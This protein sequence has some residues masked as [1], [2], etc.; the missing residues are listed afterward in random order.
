MTELDQSW[1]SINEWIVMIISIDRCDG[2]GENVGRIG[3]AVCA[4][5]D[6]SAG[7]SARRP[8]PG[9]RHRTGHRRRFHAHL[10]PLPALAQS[11]HQV[12]HSRGSR[13]RSRSSWYFSHL[14]IRATL[15][16]TFFFFFF[17]FFTRFWF[18]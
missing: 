7:A 2:L 15:I 3:C 1:I 14:I 4:D 13:S 16:S 8:A 9:R 17:F 18:Y 12:P 11:L 6:G 5:V 10:R